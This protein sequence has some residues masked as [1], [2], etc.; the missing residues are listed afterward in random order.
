LAAAEHYSC[1]HSDS[2]KTYRTLF[3]SYLC[4]D[5]VQLICTC[6][7]AW[8]ITEDPRLLRLHPG[9]FTADH[10]WRTVPAV[11]P[12]VRNLSLADEVGSTISRCSHRHSTRSDNR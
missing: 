9:R 10:V 2:G 1:V 3:I 12:D 7:P 5:S 8:F 4:T 11:C 6:S